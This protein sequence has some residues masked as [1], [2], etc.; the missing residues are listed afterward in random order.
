MPNTDA[1]PSKALLPGKDPGNGRFTKGNRLGGN[2][3]AGQI[4]RMRSALYQ[5]LTAADMKAVVRA[6]VKQAKGGNVAAS[7]LLMS[8]GLG[9]P[10]STHNHVHHGT[11]GAVVSIAVQN[12]LSGTDTLQRALEA[13]AEFLGD[14]PVAPHGEKGPP[15]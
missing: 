7:K 13:D 3:Y 8:Y 5:A 6:M 11:G 1:K 2:R 10:S 14:D 9:E 12:L 4:A 15:A